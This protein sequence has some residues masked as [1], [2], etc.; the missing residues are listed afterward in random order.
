MT[1][2]IKKGQQAGT[3]AAERQEFFYPVHD[4]IGMALEDALRNGILT[5]KQS[6]ISQ[7]VRGSQ[8]ALSTYL[9][10]CNTG[11]RERQLTSFFLPAAKAGVV[12]SCQLRNLFR[13]S[14]RY[15]GA[16]NRCHRNRKCW[17][18]EPEAAR[19]RWG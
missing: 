10:W 14:W 6:A 4:Q 7:T 5:R 8:T 12:I 17:A 19:N 13:S 11:T 18:M 3:A 16:D 15:A 9:N 1:A 2:P